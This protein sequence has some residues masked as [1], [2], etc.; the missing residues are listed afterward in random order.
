MP[1][2]AITELLAL[3]NFQVAKVPEHIDASLLFMRR[4]KMLHAERFISDEEPRQTIS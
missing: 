3:P 2:K 4:P 1:L